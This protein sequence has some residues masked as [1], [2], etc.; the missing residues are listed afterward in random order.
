MA[1]ATAPEPAPEPA[2]P[3]PPAVDWSFV[4]GLLGELPQATVDGFLARALEDARQ[5]FGGLSDPALGAEDR[6]RLAHRLKGTTRSFGLVGLGDAA[7]AVERDS[8]R[9]LDLQPALARYAR[10]LDATAGE[11]A[12]RRPARPRES[13]A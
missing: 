8:R 4:A 11:L 12:G 10:A 6:L 13:P 3:D 9:G 7:E 5:G 2:E 1:R